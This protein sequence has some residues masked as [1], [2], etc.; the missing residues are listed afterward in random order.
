LY[1]KIFN[2]EKVNPV[3]DKCPVCS[4]DLII[5]HL[6]CP[7]CRT[8]IEGKFNFP[9]SPFTNLSPDQLQFLLTFI[10][11]EGKFNRME[12]ELKLSYPTLRN[13]FDEILEQMGFEADDTSE[14]ISPEER[15]KILNDLNKGKITAGEAQIRLKGMVEK[16]PDH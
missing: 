5:T 9:H 1:L 6:H 3:I 12:E 2:G 11:C 16:S 14:E 4:D 13:R 8:T 15:K 7:H 10:R